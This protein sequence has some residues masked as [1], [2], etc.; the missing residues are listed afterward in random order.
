MRR[1]SSGHRLQAPDTPGLPHQTLF[2]E[3]KS[4]SGSGDELVMTLLDWYWT[5]LLPPQR[6]PVCWVKPRGLGFPIPGGSL[7]VVFPDPC[8][9]D[10]HRKR[11]W[12]GGPAGPTGSA[13][14]YLVEFI[15]QQAGIQ[16]QLFEVPLLHRHDHPVHLVVV[17]GSEVGEVHVG[18]DEVMA[19]HIG[20]QVAQD[21]LSVP[22][23]EQNL[24][25]DAGHLTH[26]GSTLNLQTK[27]PSWGW[28]LGWRS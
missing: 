11:Q 7:K 17:L 25:G 2:K 19:Q 1:N 13:T 16:A 9:Q 3:R 22:K 18:W 26:I 6:T 10:W 12:G 24:S 28:S 14:R 20:V 15:L 23:G 27:S 4:Q 8:A 5:E 21:L